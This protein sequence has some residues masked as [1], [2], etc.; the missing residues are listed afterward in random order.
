VGNANPSVGALK[1][2]APDSTAFVTAIDVLNVRLDLDKSNDGSVDY[3]QIVP[4]S[5]LSFI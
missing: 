5:A 2:V 3:N 1:I 4:W